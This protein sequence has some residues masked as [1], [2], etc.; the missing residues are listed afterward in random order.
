MG[1][2]LSQAMRD[3][4]VRALD[5][6]ERFAAGYFPNDGGSWSTVR[7]LERRGLLRFEGYGVDID[8]DAEGDVAIF[9]LTE[10]GLLKA[11]ALDEP[12]TPP[13]IDTEDGGTGR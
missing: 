10:A 7:A 8:G 11:R 12:S 13:P 5:L 2:E 6:H 9:Q 4:L 3:A 1:G